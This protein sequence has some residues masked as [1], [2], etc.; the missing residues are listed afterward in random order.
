MLHKGQA[1]FPLLIALVLFAGL[2]L[3][4]DAPQPSLSWSAPSTAAQWDGSVFSSQN[5]LTASSL[6]AGTITLAVSSCPPEWVCAPSPT[7]FEHDGTDATYTA[8]IM[9]I[10]PQDSTGTASVSAS[11]GDGTSAGAWLVNIAPP[12][13]AGEQPPVEQPANETLQPELPA[14]E[15]QQPANETQQ[16][17]EI[18]PAGQI[19]VPP[20]FLPVASCGKIS[21]NAFLT[22]DINAVDIATCFEF[23]APGAILDCNGHA[24]R[25]GGYAIS[26]ESVQ[27]VTVRNCVVD[28]AGTALSVISSPDF[29]ADNCSFS[30]ESWPVLVGNSRAFSFLNSKAGSP[31]ATTAA[32][33]IIASPDARITGSTLTAQSTGAVMFYESSNGALITGS[34][35]TSLGIYDSSHIKVTGSHITN[36]GKDG[37]TDSNDAVVI[38][39]VAGHLEDIEISQTD[40]AGLV[41]VNGNGADIPY[42]V[43]PGQKL[44]VSSLGNNAKDVTVEAS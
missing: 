32:L 12:P 30:A 28:G 23:A 14:N 40:V 3:S 29:T 39:S 17:L 37:E 43:G 16:P 20:G 34:T 24:I 7:T 27:G 31:E 11:A 26:A 1:R 33:M 15:S 4:Q 2:A 42:A 38:Q 6:P 41:F 21:G 8:S 25:G 44:R 13:P 35:L 5:S 18:P 22:T 9:I 10:A 36:K 19:S